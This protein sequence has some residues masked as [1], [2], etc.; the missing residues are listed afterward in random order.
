[1]REANIE[2]PCVALAEEAGWWQRKVQWVGRKGAP[3][4]VFI[5][6]GRTVW[7]EFKKPDAEPELLQEIEH[8]EMLDHGGEVFVV[9]S[10]GVFRL[11]MGIFL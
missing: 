3:D 6:D 9:D 1:M 5:K 4:R 2:S 11:I 10:V 7:V 8:Q